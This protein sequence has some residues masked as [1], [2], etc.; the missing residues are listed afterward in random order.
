LGSQHQGFTLYLLTGSQHRL[1]EEEEE[2][3]EESHSNCKQLC[4]LPVSR[5][6]P[7]CIPPF[8]LLA[9]IFPYI[10]E[11]RGEKVDLLQFP[12]CGE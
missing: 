9:I 6:V 3:E 8:S 11:R 10:E 7:P 12:G 4:S 5:E 2:E 1:E